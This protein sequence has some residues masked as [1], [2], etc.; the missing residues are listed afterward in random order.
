MGELADRRRDLERTA[1][2]VL[3][4]FATVMALVCSAVIVCGWFAGVMEDHA[5]RFFWAGA[6]LS[7]VNIGVLAAAVFPGGEDDVRTINRVRA[8]TRIGLI[9]FVGAPALCIGALIADFYG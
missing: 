1:S 2:V 8:L 3:A 4:T 9:L 7:F 5:E 6:V